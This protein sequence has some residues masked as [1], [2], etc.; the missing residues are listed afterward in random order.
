M[1]CLEYSYEVSAHMPVYSDT[2]CQ[3]PINMKLQTPGTVVDSAPIIQPVDVHRMAVND[4]AGE[5]NAM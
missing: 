5:A 4:S 2:F 1:L 3:S